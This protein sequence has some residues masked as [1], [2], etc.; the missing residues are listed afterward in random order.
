MRVKPGN[1]TRVSRSKGVN[2]TTTPPNR[3]LQCNSVPY[4]IFSSLVCKAWLFS[5]SC[6]A[7]SV[8]RR[9]YLTI[10]GSWGNRLENLTSMREISHNV[11]TVSV[12]CSFMALW[13]YQCQKKIKKVMKIK[14]K[15]YHPWP[16]PDS[17]LEHRG[18]SPWWN[19]YTSHHWRK[20]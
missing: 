4:I 3:C 12:K 14:S 17:N 19:H 9:E 5:N 18:G 16:H 10:Q 6:T 2:H 15:P 13:Y 11:C 20:M 7:G 1:R 8:T